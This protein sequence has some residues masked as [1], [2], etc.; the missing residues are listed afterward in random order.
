M[1]LSDD[2]SPETKCKPR[3]L[4]IMKTIKHKI[5][6]CLLR[7]FAKEILQFPVRF[8]LQHPADVGEAF[9]LPQ[10]ELPDMFFLTA[11]PVPSGLCFSFRFLFQLISHELLHALGLGAR[12][13]RAVALQQIDHTPYAKASAERDNE[14][15]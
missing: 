7:R 15:L 9:F 13:I 6:Y 2:E 12:V 3:I 14:G 1:L 8:H 11:P 4:M 5:Q 10:G